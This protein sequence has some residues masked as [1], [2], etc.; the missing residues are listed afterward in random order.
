[1]AQ[2]Q[3]RICRVHIRWTSPQIPFAGPAVS[4]HC[5]KIREI[6]KLNGFVM[7]LL[8]QGF[9]FFFSVFL[10]ADSVVG[11]IALRASV[12]QSGEGEAQAEQCAFLEEQLS[13]CAKENNSPVRRDR[14]W[15]IT[16]GNM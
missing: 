6:I 13:V 16:L 10:S 14:A 4:W 5:G 9:S 2:F 7:T 1:M 11:R 8:L 3:I 12:K 15:S